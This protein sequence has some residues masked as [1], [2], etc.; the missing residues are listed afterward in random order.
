MEFAA[1]DHDNAAKAALNFLAWQPHARQAGKD[2]V[3]ELPAK[4][5]IQT[6]LQWREI[7]SLAW[8]TKTGE[9][10]YRKPLSPF[11]IVVLRQRDPQGK[12]LPS[13]T[14]DVVARSSGLPDRIENDSRTAVYELTLRFQVGDQPGR[15]AIRI[16]GVQPDSTLPAEA[17]KVPGAERWELHPRLH[18]EVVDPAS[19][20]AGRVI[21]RAS[22]PE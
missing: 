8:K 3:A 18:V 22:T 6:T 5:V 11:R 4:A 7:H 16:E 1:V 14:F 10:I 12:A 19:R 15:Y 17:A 21:L 9:D 20:A 13:D 2:Q